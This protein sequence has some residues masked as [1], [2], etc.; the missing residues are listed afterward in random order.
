M[1]KNLKD[2]SEE[3]SLKLLRWR[4]SPSVASKMLNAKEITL[5]EHLSWVRRVVQD[6]TKNILVAFYDDIPVGMI[7]FRDID[8]EN[9]HAEWGF[10][11]GENKYRGRG[12][13]SLM[14]R[15]IIR[16]GFCEFKLRRLYTSVLSTNEKAIAM[17][18][19]YGFRIEGCWRE[20]LF[21]DGKP[22]DVYWMGM[23][24][25]EKRADLS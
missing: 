8:V 19:R 14:L 18:V 17:Y 5:E 23:L 3:T 16:I 4:N 7:S 21:R 15:E 22:V 1:F 11:I 24:N 6:M 20:H 12:L 13:G 9:Q 25:T 2:V 10:Y